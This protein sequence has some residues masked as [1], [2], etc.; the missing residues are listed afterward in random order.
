MTQQSDGVATTTA[1]TTDL[2]TTMAEVQ[3]EHSFRLIVASFLAAP[4]SLRLLCDTTIKQCSGDGNCRDDD[5][6]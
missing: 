6:G 2:V 4:I 5:N 1:T 3:M